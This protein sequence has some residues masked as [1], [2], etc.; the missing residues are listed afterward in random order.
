MCFLHFE[1][2]YGVIGERC[3]ELGCVGEGN[4]FVH[5]GDKDATIHTCSVVSESCV[6][7]KLGV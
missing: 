6:L 5:E 1:T 3:F 4:M 7:R 2:V